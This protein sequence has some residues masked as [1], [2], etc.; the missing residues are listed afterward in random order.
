M[1][2]L[3]AILASAIRLA[4]PYT[5]AGLG[6]TYSERSGV[7]N[8][9]L[10]GMMLTG[11]FTAVAAANLSG[12]P[13]L[14]LLA[15][16]VAGML[17]GFIHAIVCVSLKSNQIVSGVAI[18][19]FA[20]GATVFF[21]WLLFNLTQ[22]Q[23]EGKLVVPFT[24]LPP[25]LPL[26]VLIVIASHVILF[27]T[28]FGLRLRAVGEHPKAADTLGIN[29]YKMRYMGV[30]ISGG[31]GGLAGAFLSLEHAHYFVKGMSGGKGFIG[32]AAMIF[33]KWTAFGTAGAGLL[34][35]LG[36]AISLRV[37][38]V[39]IP[40]QFIDMIP[41]ILTMFVL[42]GVVGRATAPAADGIPYEKE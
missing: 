21:S 37:S 29:V 31:L 28:T 26:T 23:L 3:Y 7:V 16:I 39:G 5:L 22:I 15:A 14:G 1:S 4:V 36:E 30:M 6:G 13:W 20:S 9:G 35:G 12:S 10:E 17:L 33:G 41:Y 8:I 11:A 25:I 32:M 38:S 24:S 42:A 27:K 19:I 18:N 40:P 34:F 2:G